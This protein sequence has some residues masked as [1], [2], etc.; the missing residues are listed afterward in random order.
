MTVVDNIEEN[1][2]KGKEAVENLSKEVAKVASDKG[3]EAVK[4]AIKE[5]VVKTKSVLK[6]IEEKI[7]K[8]AEKI[9]EVIEEDA[10]K[11]K[12][13]VKKAIEKVEKKK[14]VKKKT[15]NP[16]GH[17]KDEEEFGEKEEELAE[18]E[19]LE[20]EKNPEPDLEARK[21]ALLE[22]VKKLSGKVDETKTEDLK[23][24]VKGKKKTDMLV[25]LEEYVKTGIY[26]GK[27]AVTPDMKPFV[28]R[29]R[30]DGLAIFNTDLIDEK[31]KEAVEYLAKFNPEDVILVCKRQ[32]GWE[33]AGMMSRLTGI[34]VFTKKYPAGVLTNTN[35]PDFFEN[36]LTIVTDSWIDKNALQDT[37]R[38][39]KKVLMICDTNNFAKGADKI[40]IVNNKTSKSLGIIF[41]ILTRGYCKARGIDADIP[42]LDWWVKDRE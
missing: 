38:V 7:E 12:K 18:L 1:I 20:T 11:V 10:E 41:Y 37:L 16:E 26:I 21:K 32:A 25:P 13:T 28:Y 2:E 29:R 39:K 36:E 42:D 14:P 30:A 19:S 4:K 5:D 23:E 6:K 33:A 24:Q 15:E 31:L 34:R 17:K 3:Q 35:L 9:K 27:R 22:R 40:I 8:G